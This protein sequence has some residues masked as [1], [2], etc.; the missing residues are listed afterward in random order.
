[1]RDFSGSGKGA[2]FACGVSSLCA[3]QRSPVRSYDNPLPLVFRFSFAAVFL[4]PL[5][6]STIS[7]LFVT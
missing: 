4:P 5:I 7:T 6:H 3:D 1:M 2:S